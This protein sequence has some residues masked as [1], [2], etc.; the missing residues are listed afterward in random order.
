MVVIKQTGNCYTDLN[1]S[2][3]RVDVEVEYRLDHAVVII[4]LTWKW[5]T[6]LTS[7]RYQ[8]GR[9]WTVSLPLALIQR[10]KRLY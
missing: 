6:D 9:E 8:A 7:D 10:D 5:N 4:G 1:S 3:Y 2:H